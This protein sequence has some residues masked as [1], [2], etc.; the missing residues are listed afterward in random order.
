MPLAEPT[1]EIKMIFSR[2]VIQAFKKRY[3]ALTIEE[4]CHKAFEALSE[5]V[6]SGVHISE[7]TMREMATILASQEITSEQDLI[8]FA[9][10]RFN[11][12]P[13]QVLVDIDPTL[14]YYIREVAEREKISFGQSVVNYFHN[15]FAQGW[16]NVYAY[17]SWIAFTTKEWKRL[18]EILGKAPATSQTLMRILE[19]WKVRREAVAIPPQTVVINPQSNQNESSNPIS[20][21]GQG[22]SF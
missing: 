22:I 1:F 17:E 11:I 8:R 6:G 15:A 13:T 16:F 12:L 18:K 10:E 2:K 7:A 4:S 3:P 19:D 9:R 14:C 5:Q 21:T 20:V